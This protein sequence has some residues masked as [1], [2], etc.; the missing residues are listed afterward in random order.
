M[1]ANIGGSSETGTAICH[2]V[3]LM[4]IRAVT[5]SAESKVTDFT[6]MG[7]L[8]DHSFKTAAF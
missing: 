8:M 2:K 7:A 1:S 4:G 5:I 6:S 3:M